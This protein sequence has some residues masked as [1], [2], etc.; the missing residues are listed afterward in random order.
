MLSRWLLSV[1]HRTSVDGETE[2]ARAQNM[3]EIE[4]SK[5]NDTWLAV[6]Q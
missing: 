3:H 5:L 2:L 4:N 6:A 1:E